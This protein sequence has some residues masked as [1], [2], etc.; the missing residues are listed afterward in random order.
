MKKHR[1]HFQRIKDFLFFPLRALLLPEKDCFG[2]SSWASERFYYVAHE[3]GDYC[4]DVGCGRD[5]RF[6]KEFLGGRG[7]GM[8]VYYYDGLTEENILKDPTNFPF[9]S[10]E[11]DSVTF[12]AN[13]NH[14]PEHLRLL[15]LKEAFRVLK[16]GGNIIITMGNPILEIAAH[17]LLKIHEKIFRQENIYHEHG[18]PEE[19]IYYL[20]D[21]EI[22]ELLAEAGFG[23]IKKKYF[24]T[25]WG[26]NHVF[27]G[28]K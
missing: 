4:L 20:K 25:Q 12:I 11:F 1:S 13:I 6:I 22:K 14:I 9:S 3:S 23:H 2:L 17:K 21:K 27:I 16:N 28:I 19:E 18:G 24:W 7:K 15:E 10:H 5:N 8:D 26:L